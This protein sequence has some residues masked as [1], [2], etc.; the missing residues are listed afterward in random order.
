VL[1]ETNGVITEERFQKM[2]PIQWNFQYR[3][4]K[5]Y[6]SE[7]RK[8]EIQNQ[9]LLQSMLAEDIE[10]LAMVIN[11]KIA[12]EF[13]EMKSKRRNEIREKLLPSDSKKKTDGSNAPTINNV[14]ITDEK[15]LEEIMRRDYD[16]V[17][18]TIIVPAAVINQNKFVLPKFSK[19]S[20]KDKNRR[21]I[22]MSPEKAVEKTTT[23]DMP[24]IKIVPKTSRKNKGKITLT[25]EGENH[26]NG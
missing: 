2:T 7:L 11:P 9:I 6:R 17:P 13:I 12:K 26:G 4:I 1:A 24:S 20:L 16:T 25:G 15:A 21:F 23:I 18:D 22:Q 3:A 19:G 10:T 14:D 8:Q 5:K